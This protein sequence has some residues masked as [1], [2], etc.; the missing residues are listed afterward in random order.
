MAKTELWHR[1]GDT[2]LSAPNLTLAAFLGHAPSIAVAK[3][4]SINFPK[5]ADFQI[6][7][8]YDPNI[9]KLDLDADYLSASFLIRCASA[10]GGEVLLRVVNSCSLLQI[11]HHSSCSP[12]IR[13][14]RDEVAFTLHA[15]IDAPSPPVHQKAT[16]LLKRC[17]VLYRHQEAS[18]DSNDSALMW[19][20]LGAP[21]CGLETALGNLGAR[22]DC[23]ETEPA[24]SNST[25]SARETVWPTRAMDAA[26]H[27]SS[28]SIVRDVIRSSLVAW[29][30]SRTE[31]E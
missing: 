1:F 19:Y 31:N 15:L 7:P 26:S 11:A 16:E 25:W 18:S 28:H 3:Q 30:V 5:S 14:L 29:A 2:I 23:G 13:R 27:W 8:A 21:W 22:R 17:Q 10:W 6:D 9:H 20:D 24:P 4:R 12:G